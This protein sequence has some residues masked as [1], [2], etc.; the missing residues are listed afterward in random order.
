MNSSTSNPY[1][2]V[3]RCDPIGGP[4]LTD[5]APRDG[6]IQ[7]VCVFP[8][9]ISVCSRTFP[10]SHPPVRVH[11]GT[12]AYPLDKSSLSLASRIRRVQVHAAR[13]D[14]FRSRSRVNLR[15]DP[16]MSP[17]AIHLHASNTGGQRQLGQ[18]SVRYPN[19]RVVLI[20]VQVA[21]V[22]PHKLYNRCGWAAL[23]NV[24]GVPVPGASFSVHL[25]E[26]RVIGIVQVSIF[27]AMLHVRYP[28]V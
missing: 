10:P 8:C 23:D 20:L 3:V 2:L 1:E 19:V 11:S 25:R 4:A 15:R 26:D 6:N 13:S 18:V 9:I 5:T 7:Y 21:G 27:S 28:N 24:C 17:S 12:C 16:R 22:P 14:L